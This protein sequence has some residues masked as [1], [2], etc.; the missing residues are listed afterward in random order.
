M[1]EPP[2]KFNRKTGTDVMH[3]GRYEIS[4]VA[5]LFARGLHRTEEFYLAS[6]LDGVGAL[7]DLVFLYKLRNSNVWKTCFIQLKHKKNGGDIDKSSLTKMDGHYSLF[8]YFQSYCQIKNSA[9]S[10]LKQ[11]GTFDEY[12]FI[13]YTNA[14]LKVDYILKE[15]NSDPVSILSS[16]KGNCKYITFVENHDKDIFEFFKELELFADCILKLENSIKDQGLK[17]DQVEK[18]I[19]GFQ[20]MFSR[21]EIKNSLELLK[22]NPS[23]R[24]KMVTKLKICNFSLYREFLSKVKIFQNQPH[25][26]FFE[27]LI[28]KELQAACQVS[29]SCAKSIYSEFKKGLNEW[30]DKS[31]AVKWLSKDFYAWKIV[32]QNLMDEIV[33][34]SK[35]KFHETVGYVLLFN[36]QHIDGLSEAIK[37]NNLLNII[38][39]QEFNTLSKLKTRQTLLSLDYRNSLFINLKDL[40]SGYK[41][42][43][44]LWPCEWSSALVIDCQQTSNILNDNVVSTIVDTLVSVLSLSR[45]KVILISESEHVHFASHLRKKAGNIYNYI[46]ENCKFSDLD[47]ESQKQVLGKTVKFQGKDVALEKLVGTDPPDCIKRLITTNV[48]SI[49]MSHNPQLNVGKPLCHHISYYIP[50][51][52]ARYIRLNIDILQLR[53]ETNLFAVSGLQADELKKYLPAGEEIFEFISN[54]EEASYSFHKV[55]DVSKSDLSTEMKTKERRHKVGRNVKPKGVRYVILGDLKPE[56]DFRKLKELF[57]NAH[58]IHMEEGSFLWRESSSNIDIIRRYIDEGNYKSYGMNEIMVHSD[59]IMLL[60]AEPGMGKTTFLSCMEYEIK[61]LNPSVWILRINLLEHTAALKNFDSEKECTEKCKKFLWNAAH[62]SEKEQDVVNLEEKIFLEFLNQEGKMVIILDD[63]DQ[64]SPDYSPEVEMLL[65][66]IREGTK[67]KIWVSSRLSCRQKLEDTLIS[68]AFTLQPFSQEN[69]IEFLYQYWNKFINLSNPENLRVFAEE[70]LSF[71]SKNFSDKNEDFFSIPL[72]TEVL[73]KEF[74]KET[75]EFCLN[76]EVKLRETFN[77]FLL[78]KIIDKKFDIYFS[79]KNMMDIT[80]PLITRWKNS[81]L[82]KHKIAALMF[83]FSEDIVNRQFETRNAR[84][85]EQVKHFLYSGEAEHFGIIT[86]TTDEQ[87]RF[88]HRRFAE[89]FA[90]K[91]FTDNVTNCESFIQT[92]FNYTYEE[93]IEDFLYLTVTSADIFCCNTN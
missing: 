75:E 48:I 64:V 63:F 25:Q 31:R 13:I 29:L 35:T 49:L 33:K 30:C 46:E 44:N 81:Y 47:T 9:D 41:N 66:A 93:K 53:D 11:Y 78:H 12:E 87:P 82:E 39:K 28:N 59:R 50:R 42:I 54:E 85:F 73:G 34:F 71:F 69:Q 14:R 91:W 68:L 40:L 79:E 74:L 51:V 65:R 89:Y 17:E 55:A 62:S 32:K 52:A 61:K 2:P 58:W 20:S 24:E 57:T 86:G 18:A 90:A 37:Q 45:T 43:F 77:S 19:Q 38:T 26:K 67:S 3:G 72:H 15:D 27:Q 21:Q 23:E 16:M 92:L 7:D 60:V 80:K 83:F 22:S 36:Q 76:G 1:G 70:I 5:F 10:N 84:D 88:I 8:K 6:N 56:S 4:M